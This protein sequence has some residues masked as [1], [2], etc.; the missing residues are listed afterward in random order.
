MSG[1]LSSVKGRELEDGH[2]PSPGGESVSPSQCE[3]GSLNSYPQLWLTVLLQ[4]VG[5]QTLK[6]DPT[7]KGTQPLVNRSMVLG[8]GRGH[9]QQS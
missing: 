4:Q 8:W 2:V 3:P 1:P 7:D 5:S 6:G 9:S